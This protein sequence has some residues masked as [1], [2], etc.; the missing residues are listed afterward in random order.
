MNADLRK[1]VDKLYLRLDKLATK[2]KEFIL[3]YY[4]LVDELVDKGEYYVLEQT[5]Y[6]YY[7]INPSA[8]NNTEDLKKKTW[9]QIMFQTNSSL[10][11]K[12]KK[13]YDD[14]LIYQIGY[15]IYSES[16]DR[17]EIS[18]SDALTS[19]YSISSSTQSIVATRT[20]D[21]IYIS[22]N[23]SSV[24][25]IDILRSEWSVINDVDQPIDGS[26]SQLQS[27]YVTQSTSYRTEIPITH[28][29]TY[30]LKSYSN[31][32][33]NYNYKLDLVKDSILGQIYEIDSWTQDTK[34]YVQNKQFAKIIGSRS[35]YLETI[36]QSATQSYLIDDEDPSLT[37]DQN[38]VRRYTI[39]INYLLS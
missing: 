8:F 26:L 38:L 18:I 9:D 1:K 29:R 17:L 34:Y 28:G 12:I 32:Y 31:V 2:G 36:K 11:K 20:G 19:T 22:T 30:L 6:F 35:T 16:N 27:I 39:A 25:Q 24:Y 5:L 21:N 10:S 37:E 23:D 13:V 3:D 7:N 14:N 33:N 4:K 15:N